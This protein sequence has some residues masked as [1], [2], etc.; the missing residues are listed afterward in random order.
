MTAKAFCFVSAALMLVCTST[1]WAAGT[2]APLVGVCQS[3][4][5]AAV[6]K[7]AG[8]DY[9]E[10]SARRVLVPLEAE[11]VFAKNYRDLTHSPLPVYS[12][13]VFIP[14]S[15]P[16]TG[17]EAD[18]DAVLA[19]C[20]TAFQRARRCGSK[21]IGF[22]SCA[23]RGYPQGFS[24]VEAS[25]QFVALLRRMGPLATQ[26]EIVVA[27]EPLHRGECNFI[28][29]L[30][31]AA[32]ICRA[33]DHANIGVLVDVYHMLMENEAPEAIVEAGRWVV[34]CHIAE[35]KDRAAPGTHGEDLTPYLKALKEIDYTGRIS[36]E[37]RWTALEE[38]LPEAGRYLREQIAS[39]Q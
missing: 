28:N 24:P 22:G 18:H 19:Y 3:S 31:E 32:A 7:A 37:C 33:V 12:Y 21:V 36:I 11:D 39:C 16:C 38:Q 35:K 26:H 13:N 10:E 5:K 1:V 4:K 15:L 17:P 20:A 23:A 14:G 25:A 9:V 27:V 34:H 30:S 6:I 29:R 2:F 8:F